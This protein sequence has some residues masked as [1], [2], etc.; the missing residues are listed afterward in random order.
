M[1]I[2]GI[3]IDIVDLDD[4]R[5]RL[6]DAVVSE[7]FLPAEIE[8]ARSQARPWE[9]LGARLAAKEA[10]LKALG[11]GFRQ[12][13]SLKQVEVVSQSSGAVT[14][15]FAGRAE[16]R[17]VESGVTNA[18]LSMTHSSRSAAAVVVLEGRE[19]GTDLDADGDSEIPR[20]QR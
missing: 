12:G 11:A 18:R 10:A 9:S 16:S 13:L 7:V 6:S 8:Y 3:G 17:A 15:R 1:V 5:T 19:R 4:F 2:I 14:L 20:G